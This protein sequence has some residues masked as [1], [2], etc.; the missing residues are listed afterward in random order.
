MI[1]KHRTILRLRSRLDTK[2]SSRHSY[3]V[4]VRLALA[5]VLVGSYILQ[6]FID[7]LEHPIR[8]PGYHRLELA[9][10]LEDHLEELL[11]WSGP[12]DLHEGAEDEVVEDVV[13]DLLEVPTRE[14]LHQGLERG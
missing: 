3:V 6:P 12:D 2:V 7:H 9:Q 13:A 14:Q 1:W 4:G 5:R 10:E 8:V 11:G